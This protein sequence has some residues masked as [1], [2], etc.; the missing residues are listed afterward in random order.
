[1]GWM[2][3]YSG[4][5]AV[6]A[7]LA[8]C[9][10]LISAPA[11]ATVKVVIDLSEQTMTVDTGSSSGVQN[12]KVSTARRGYR[13]PLGNHQPYLMKRKHF[14]SLYDNAPMPYSIFF[15]GNYAIH[16]TTAL[17]SLGRPA[18]HGCVR[19][20]PDNARMLFEIVQQA[21]M[22]NTQIIVVP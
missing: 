6:G 22:P 17:K 3:R 13:T 7:A 2:N 16:G 5:N 14:S 10:L 12:W 8:V 18:S 15:K 1:M 21:G 9:V 11:N 4:F 19:L 20:H